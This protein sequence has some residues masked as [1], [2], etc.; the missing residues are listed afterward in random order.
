MSQ[1]T[2]FK[3]EEVRDFFQRHPA[4]FHAEANPE[5]QMASDAQPRDESSDQTIVGYRLLEKMGSGG[6]AMVFKAEHMATGT[7]VALKLLY[8]S[9]NKKVLKQFLHEGMVLMKLDHPNILKGFD[10]GISQGIY[11]LAL[12]FIEGESLVP[13]LE[14]G[15]FFTEI[16]TFQVALQIARALAYLES[17]GIVHR[18]VKPA[19]ILIVADTVKLCDFALS[20]DTTRGHNKEQDSETTC[21]TVEYISPEQAR[22]EQELDSRSDVYSLGIT[23]IHM[24]TGKIP[25]HGSDP[26]EIMRQQV[27]E[28][29]DWEK[30]S[31]ISQPVRTIL[32]A[33]VTKKLEKRL[34]ARRLVRV[35]EKFLEGRSVG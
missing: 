31:N 24:L 25:F 11:F 20:L 23:C 6:M 1:D 13:F 16:Y 27:Y 32:K 19:N 30:F 21:G 10:F 2:P 4:R 3:L 18:D 34:V 17:K 14:K 28:P 7:V 5:L 35:L 8:P 15:F 12:E 22:G 29:I 26:Q 33:M 9:H